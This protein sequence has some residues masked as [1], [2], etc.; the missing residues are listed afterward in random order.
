MFYIFFVYIFIC[1]AVL[2]FSRFAVRR[3]KDFL[4][5]GLCEAWADL[6]IVLNT[7]SRL[8]KLRHMQDLCE[9][10]T[11]TKLKCISSQL[12]FLPMS[13]NKLQA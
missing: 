2:R 6:W 8:P 7:V 4:M 11:E 1:F 12:R 3:N 9:E 13:L 5:K 10:K